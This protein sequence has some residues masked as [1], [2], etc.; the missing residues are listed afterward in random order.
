[1][2]VELQRIKKIV[3]LNK[4]NNVTNQFS[5]NHLFLS[6]SHKFSLLNTAAYNNLKTSLSLPKKKYFLPRSSLYSIHIPDPPVNFSKH[7]FIHIKCIRKILH[8]KSLKKES[9]AFKILIYNWKTNAK[10][11][12]KSLFAYNCKNFFGQG[13][14][15]IYLLFGLNDK[16]NLPEWKMLQ[17]TTI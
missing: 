16:T 7:L 9:P 8:T 3:F 5:I 14:E 2:E 12:L 17:T 6:N 11:L 10:T 1:M 4:L 15:K 13:S